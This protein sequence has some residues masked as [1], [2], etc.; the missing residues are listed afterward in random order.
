MKRIR[1][2]SLLALAF[3]S[4][5]SSG[6]KAQ[7]IAVAANQNQN[8]IE[9]LGFP[10]SYVV[11]PSSTAPYSVSW[12]WQQTDCNPASSFRQADDYGKYNYGIPGTFLLKAVITYQSV[13]NPNLHPNPP[14]PET[15]TRSVTISPPDI[16]QT[17]GPSM[18]TDYCTTK[19]G[20]NANPMTPDSL[21][22]QPG[23][24]IF[25]E[26]TSANKPIGPQLSGLTAQERLTKFTVQGTPTPND[27]SWLPSGPD[28][29]FYL[30]RENDAP[31]N[32]VICDFKCA[33][34][35][36]PNTYPAGELATYTQENRVNWTNFNGTVISYSLGSRNWT[37]TGTNNPNQWYNSSQ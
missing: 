21:G 10:T 11:T 22:G 31:Y 34:P 27:D 7:G 1:F 33:T 8:Q 9:Q 5:A 29:R 35:I 6:A 32:L 23:N 24:W 3:L 25:F 13:S 15:L 19:P 4:V 36:A 30:G 12:T 37:I 26:L 14:P 20:P 18:L 17:T 2:A 28:T 16:S